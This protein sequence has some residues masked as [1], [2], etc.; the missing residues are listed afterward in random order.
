[1]FKNIFKKRKAF[2]K[3]SYILIQCYIDKNRNQ[4]IVSLKETE[5]GFYAVSKPY[6]FHKSNEF[7]DISNTV[8][9][10]ID[11]I[12][13][14]PFIDSKSSESDEVYSAMLNGK[15]YKKFCEE[16]IYVCIKYKVC[17][18]YYEV[19]NYPKIPQKSDYNIIKNTFSEKYSTKYICHTQQEIQEA[20][21]KAYE[22]GLAYLEAIGEP[23]KDPKDYM[24]TDKSRKSNKPDNN[25]TDNNNNHKDIISEVPLYKNTWLVLKNDDNDGF[26]RLLSDI[27]NKSKTTYNQALQS[28]QEDKIMITGLYDDYYVIS[29]FNIPS[30]DKTE[31]VKSLL[32]K[33]SNYSSEIAYYSSFRTVDL[34]GF[35]YMKDKKL[36]RL[37]S[38]C[39]SILANIGDKLPIEDKLNINLTD[40][41][42]NLFKEGYDLLDEEILTNISNGLSLPLEDLIGRQQEDTYTFDVEDLY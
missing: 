9:Q 32:D 3:N 36:L 19:N 30:G 21:E 42:D 20:I 4:T 16:Y 35:A 23:L 8:L 25:S 27:K 2:D 26:S 10:Y 17:D 31:E 38:Y 11:E 12:E 33:L 24:N 34:F 39:D 7:K 22:E 5:I 18:D 13:K 41:D 28:S 14:D 6:S 40:N 29:G 37:Y 15:S 1:M